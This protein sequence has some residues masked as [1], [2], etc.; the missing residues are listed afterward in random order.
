MRHYGWKKDADDSRD[1]K[2]GLSWFSAARYMPLTFLPDDIDVGPWMPEVMDQG[3]TSTCTCHAVEELLRYNLINNG[4]QGADVPLSR[5]YL[6]E[7]AGLA[8]GD[9]SDDGRQIRDVI[10]AAAAGVPPEALWDF[11]K[12]CQP[13]PADVQAKAT[14]RADDYS[15]VEMSDAGIITA[16]YVG[17]PFVIG[18]PVYP[19]FESDEVAETGQVPMPT[20]GQTPIG[21]HAMATYRIQRRAGLAWSQ[22]SWGKGWAVGGRCSFPVEYLKKYATDTWTIRNT[23]VES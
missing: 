7:M 3:E 13:I 23:I 18:I 21:Q 2:F 15:K 1:K 4:G 11:D 22:N 8:E 9:T 19:A 17:R 12:L 6:Y 20:W 16:L 14:I 10:K 5:A